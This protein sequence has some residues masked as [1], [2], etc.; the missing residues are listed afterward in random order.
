MPAYNPLGGFQF[1]TDA[2]LRSF[3]FVC[4]VFRFAFASHAY[5]R[6]ARAPILKFWNPV[7][8][9]ANT[10][11]SATTPEPPAG[12]SRPRSRSCS[13]KALNYVEYS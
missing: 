7:A 1:E 8:R 5:L 4:T 13:S 9:I 6:S 12:A 11:Y 2:A 3:W 10:A